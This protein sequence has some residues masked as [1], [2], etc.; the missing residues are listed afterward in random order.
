MRSWGGEGPF[1]PPW[2]HVKAEQ[3]SVCVCVSSLLFRGVKIAPAEPSGGLTELEG[4]SGWV[5]WGAAVWG[6]VG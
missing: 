6:V 5:L 4:G 1:Q 2:C 3:S